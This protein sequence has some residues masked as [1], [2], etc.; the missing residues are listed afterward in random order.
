MFESILGYIVGGIVIGVLARII[1]PGAGSMGWIVTI[2]LG[3]L[4]AVL[5]GWIAAQLAIT[6]TWLTWAIAVLAAIVL[7]FVYEMVRGK[8]KRAGTPS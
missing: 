5:G 3:I 7:L 8:G 6:S 4:G 2:L 1:K